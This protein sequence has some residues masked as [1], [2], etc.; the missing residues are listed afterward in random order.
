MDIKAIW[1][2]AKKQIMDKVTALSFDL[3]IK[4][5]EPLEFKDGVFTLVAYSVAAKNQAMDERHFKHIDFE[6]RDAAP[7][8]EEVKII[9]AAEKEARD[10]EAKLSKEI[11]TLPPAATR[12]R[13]IPLNPTK[14]FETF[15]VGKSN[16]FVAAAAEAVAKN[17]GKKINPLFIYGN[18]GLGKTHLL[19]SIANHIA[20]E[21]PKLKVTFTSCENF[22]ND[23]VEA[24]RTKTTSALREAYRNIDVLLIDDIHDIENKPGTQEEFFHTFNDLY[25]NNRQIVLVSDRHADKFTTLE[26]RMRSRFKSGL[27]QDITS[28]DVELRMAIIQ[29][30]AML[31]NQRI[32]KEVVE[33]LAQKAYEQ[34]MNIRD[35]EAILFKVIFYAG[36]KNRL[37]PTLEDCEGAFETPSED[38][39]ARATATSILETV[40]KYFN[41]AKTDITGMRRNREFVE[42]RMIAVY[43]MC[44]VL[45]IPLSNIGNLLGGRDHTTVMHSRNR[46]ASM[47]KTDERVKRIVIDLQRLIDN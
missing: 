4:T 6:I 43:L 25:Q 5:L 17:P 33:F 24:I 3:W 27:I 22:V 46:I 38:S 42:P 2:A 36:L 7:I 40:A 9:D 15:I 29:K 20:L 39:K 12:R 30:K 14:T 1:K 32:D 34:N 19:H 13:F 21:N 18:S 44:E 35:M 37:S 11:K 31:E 28:P 10:E 26:D 8:V 41:I 16:E 23:Y 45:N 47:I